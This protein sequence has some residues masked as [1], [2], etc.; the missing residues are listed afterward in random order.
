MIAAAFTLVPQASPPRDLAAEM[1]RVR[2]EA[3]AS[4]PQDDRVAPDARLD[5]A[6]A[7]LAAGRPLLAFYLF[8]MPWESARAWTFVKASTEVASTDAFVK[9]WTATGEPRP[10]AGPRRTR[11]PVLV[12]AL[13]SAA[14]AR[15]VTTYHASKA[16]GEDAGVPAGLYYLGDSHAVVQ[17]AAFAR[18]L[19]WPIPAAAPP[20]RSIT[21]ELNALDAEMTTAYEKMERSNHPAY[22]QASAVLKQAKTLN[23]HGQFAGALF[24]YLLSTYLFAPLRGAAVPRE[25]TPAQVAE[26]RQALAAGVD[27]SIAE[28]FLQLA[29]EG[30]TSTV[31]AQRLGSGA[32]LD[33][34]LPA[35]LRAIGPDTRSSTAPAPAE[36]TITLV[37]WPFT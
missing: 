32:V 20:L 16:Y 30:T 31:P 29:D 26:A 25:A 10:V 2:A 6:K 14:E 15:A 24:E 34:V 28:L 22:I 17:F 11:L 9:K 7:A 23:E 27:H 36:V 8:E 12:D 4:T 3:S 19:D 37:R 35:Y 21:G 1:D 18:A 13:A 5:R 33:A